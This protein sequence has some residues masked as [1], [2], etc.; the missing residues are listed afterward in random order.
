MLNEKHT[1]LAVDDEP[2]NLRMIERCLRRYYRVL[3]APSGEA[4][5]EVLKKET[6]SL[7]ITD[8]RMP[9]L[10]GT[11]MLRKGRLINPDMVCMVLTANA[12]TDTFI[13]AVKN[14]G[15]IRVLSKPWEPARLIE[16]VRAALEKYDILRE[17]KKAISQMKL[18]S[19]NLDR[20]S[21]R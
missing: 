2:A 21:R 15:A 6:V 14:S 19:E 1:I 18:A 16:H 7:V 9:G 12:D 17:N 10:S 20:I 4:A 11:E 5:L 8:Q 13:D 3:T